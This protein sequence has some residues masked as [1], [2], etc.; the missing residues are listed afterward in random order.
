L[1]DENNVPLEKTFFKDAAC[2]N[3]KIDYETDGNAYIATILTIQ[4]QAITLGN[5]KFENKWTI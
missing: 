1:Y 5:A 2:V 4:A 3:M